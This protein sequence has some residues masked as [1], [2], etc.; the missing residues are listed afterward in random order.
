MTELIPVRRRHSIEETPACSEPPERLLPLDSSAGIPESNGD[1]WF[2][3]NSVRLDVLMR[4][5]VE[6]VREDGRLIVR[7]FRPITADDILGGLLPITG[8]SGCNEAYY[9]VPGSHQMAH[10]LT[11]TSCHCL[12]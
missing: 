1:G 7:S 8:L 4:V 5:N 11:Q 2:E 10:V 6:L 3:G 9:P 12:R